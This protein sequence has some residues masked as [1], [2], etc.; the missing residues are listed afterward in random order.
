MLFW[1][2]FEECFE[3]LLCCLLEF[4]RATSCSASSSIESVS[5]GETS[6]DQMSERESSWSPECWLIWSF[7][8][9]DGEIRSFEDCELE[10]GLDW[11]KQK[12]CF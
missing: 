7:D 1:W 4:R 8:P 5:V 6:T 9:G 11:L 12:K 3:E 2:G 10:R